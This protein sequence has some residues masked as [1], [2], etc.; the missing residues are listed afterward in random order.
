MNVMILSIR[1]FALTVGVLS[2]S[3]VSMAQ[4]KN[5]TDAAVEYNKFKS[6]LMSQDVEAATRALG[7][8]KNSIDLAA[9]HPDT[10]ESPKTLLY[11]GDIYSSIPIVQAMKENDTLYGVSADDA[12]NTSIDAFT[13]GYKLAS[14]KKYKQGIESSVEEKVMLFAMAGNKAFED[15]LFAEA[16]EAYELIV[17]YRKAINVFDS[18]TLY[19]AAL[20]Y[21]EAENWAKAAEGYA[22]LS[23]AGYKE[24]RSAALAAHAYRETKDYEK[25]ISVINKAREKDPSSKELLLELVNTN[26]AAGNSAGAQKALN[27]AI[28]SDPNNKRLHYTIGTIYID[29]GDNEEAE[30]SLNKALEIDPDYED[31]QYQLGAHLVTWAG[32]LSTKAKNLKIGDPNYNTMIAESEEIYKRALVPLEKYIGNNPNDK[33]VLTILFQIHRSLG[34]SEK[35]LE[36]KKRAD[37]L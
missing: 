29:L 11:K 21:M 22:E 1:S 3:T 24:S 36:Y 18:T 16:A 25:A 13:N 6:A 17:R 12:I 15:S 32:E 10:K 23:K 14:K 8:A 19:N 2:I 33:Q 20:C 9:E 31:A 27:D 30:K 26:I 35:A 7:K 4:T 34:N 28:A 5:E 37:A